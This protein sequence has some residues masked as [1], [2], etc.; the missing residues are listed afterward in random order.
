M[1][2]L[3]NSE[4]SKVYEERLKMEDEIKK[5]RLILKLAAR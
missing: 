4:K 3:L 2:T 5:L 1:N